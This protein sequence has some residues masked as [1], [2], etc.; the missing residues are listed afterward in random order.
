MSNLLFREK[1]EKRL[2]A[3][4]PQS[5]LLKTHIAHIR[6][7]PRRKDTTHIRHYTKRQTFF[8]VRF[9]LQLERR[10]KLP[11]KSYLTSVRA[12]LRLRVLMVSMSL[13]VRA[14][15]GIRLRAVMTVARRVLLFVVVVLS[16]ADWILRRRENV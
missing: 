7:F 15:G 8:F 13:V 16:R 10:I 9:V 14:D 2:N 4:S 12:R 3:F 6:Y 1:K 5:F 11:Q